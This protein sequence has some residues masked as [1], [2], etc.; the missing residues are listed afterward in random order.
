MDKGC[1]LAHLIC[2]HRHS[3]LFST[4]CFIT[5]LGGCFHWWSHYALL[6]SWRKEITGLVRGPTDYCGIQ[7]TS[8][9][10]Q[11]VGNRT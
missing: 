1:I 9:H 2:G 5:V 4:G 6:V 11:I 10:P 3:Q 7:T 8:L